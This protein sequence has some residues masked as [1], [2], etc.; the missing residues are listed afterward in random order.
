[1]SF[2]CHELP[3]D[4][5]FIYGDGHN[6]N[7]VITDEV[8]SSLDA[9]TPSRK[10]ASTLD[11]AFIIMEP[12]SPRAA[13]QK[14]KQ[15]TFDDYSATTGSRDTTDEARDTEEGAA[16]H[17]V[18][19]GVASS[20][21]DE[22]APKMPMDHQRFV[23]DG[24]VVEEQVNQ[25]HVDLVSANN[26][27]FCCGTDSLGGVT[28][29]DCIFLNPSSFIQQGPK[30]MAHIPDDLALADDKR[31]EMEM[32]SSMAIGNLPTV[33][34]EEEL[35]DSI[36]GEEDKQLGQNAPVLSSGSLNASVSDTALANRDFAI[37][38]DWCIYDE[39]GFK[40][41]PSDELQNR[42]PMP[43]SEALLLS[44]SV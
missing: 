25:D 20:D 9:D 44:R 42:S 37:N 21:S 23:R 10:L 24:P 16:E 32:E 35:D 34:E 8:S 39:Y 31:L 2:P 6:S 4:E 22:Y 12:Q 5:I 19:L 27:W 29:L 7:G 33:P 13:A 41:A 38:A 26:S 3:P 14:N 30:G 1:M 43:I 28:D 11:H 15:F 36:L 18:T 40:K 17:R